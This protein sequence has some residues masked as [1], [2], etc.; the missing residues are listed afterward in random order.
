[1]NQQIN[2]N[3]VNAM[4]AAVQNQ[5]NQFADQVVL[6]QG[7][8]AAATARIAELED[9]LKAVGDKGSDAEAPRPA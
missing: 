7:R 6:L 8:L 3:E 1:M 2:V 4:L 5:R 9:Q